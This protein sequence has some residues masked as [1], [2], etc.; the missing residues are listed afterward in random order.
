[1]SEN[2][3]LS[4]MK[5]SPMTL[6]KSW[7]FSAL[8]IGGFVS[9]IGSYFTVIA[10]VFLALDFTK[11]LPENIATQ[12]VA[13]ISTFAVIPMIFLGPVGGAIADRI[14]RKKVLYMSD[15][16]GAFAAFSLFFSTKIWHLYVFSIINASVRQ[17]FYPA[18][19]ASLPK[20]VKRELLLS[21]NGLIQST[22]QLSRIIGPLIAGFVTAAFGLKVAFLVDGATY[23]FSSIL[24]VSIKT[25]LR[26]KKNGEKVTVRGVFGDLKEG[27][28]LVINDNILRFIL[29]VF[30]FTILAIGLLDP[31]IVPYLNLEF[32]LGEKEFGILMSFSAISGIIAAVILSAKKQMK[33]KILFMLSVIVLLGTLTLVIGIA[34]YLPS[35]V[36]WLFVGFSAIGV[37][38][39]GFNVPFS[40]LLQKIVRNEHLGKISGII[41]TVLNTG[42]LIASLSAVILSHFMSISMIFIL[43]SLVIF[44]AGIIGLLIN[45]AKHYDSI[46]NLREKEMTELLKKESKTQEQ[47]EVI[48]QKISPKD[49]VIEGVSMEPAL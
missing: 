5:P 28:S 49:E 17:F 26:P 4:E 8:F 2:K 40:T 44:S 27:F 11:G 29:I 38:N 12:E 24:I 30:F 45:K 7:D 10:I 43:I 16:V 25:D 3:E 39:V 20:I 18:K 42:S 13:L 35:K 37:V 46:A 9:N 21:A 32:G 33:R 23:I 48:R 6:L 47:Q 36:V 19:Q 34:P 14:D 22:Q 1:M 31:L 15:L 41:D